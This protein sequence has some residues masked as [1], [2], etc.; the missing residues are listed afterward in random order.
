MLSSMHFGT[1]SGLL[2]ELLKI[3]KRKKIKEL[4]FKAQFIGEAH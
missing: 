2:Q 4:F 1:P 3:K